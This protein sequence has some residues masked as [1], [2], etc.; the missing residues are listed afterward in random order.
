MIRIGLYGKRH[1][2][3]LRKTT[4]LFACVLRTIASGFASTLYEGISPLNPEESLKTM[5]VKDGFSMELVAAEPLVEEPVLF[6]FDANGRMYVAEMLS[7]MQ[8]SIPIL[9]S[10]NPGNDLR[11][12]VESAGAGLVSWNGDD[13]ARHHDHK[14]S[15]DNEPVL[16][17]YGTR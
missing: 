2:S 8:A 5:V 6:E 12:V 4:S 3:A 10:V 11:E 1:V 16:A 13:D 14:F 17:A 7:Y 9:G 15:Q